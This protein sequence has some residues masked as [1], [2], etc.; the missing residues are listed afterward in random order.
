MDLTKL[1]L[2]KCAQLGTGEAAEYFSVSPTTIN[3]WNNGANLPSAAAIQKVFDEFLKETPL[4]NFGNSNAKVR[5]LLPIY[6]SIDPLTHRS[7][8][9]TI[10]NYG[11][12]NVE[13]K[14]VTRTLI[15]EARSQLIHEF[16]ASESEYCVFVDKDVVLPCRAP[17]FTKGIGMDIPLE[18]ARIDA[19][20]RIMSHPADKT[21]VGGLYRDRKGNNKVCCGSA[22]TSSA[23]NAE[24][25]GLFSG[26]STDLGSLVAD[27]WVGFGFVRIH[28]SVFEDMQKRSDEIKEIKPAHG[29]IWGYFFNGNGVGED[30]SFCRRAQKIGHTTYIDT[31]I[32][33]GHVGSKVY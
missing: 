20:T 23:R 6:E 25:N 16:L 30:V 24:L 22:H 11:G 8:I 19:L 13:I 18:K 15:A 9:R 27:G 31:G 10:R 2:D 7:L 26:S 1:V 3:K 14:T 28:R 17:A 33:M 21:I 12:D 32:L 29:N 4:E 5:L